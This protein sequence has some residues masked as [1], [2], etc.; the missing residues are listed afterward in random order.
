MSDLWNVN[1]IRYCPFSWRSAKNQ[2]KNTVD[3]GP[4]QFGRG[5]HKV[6]LRGIKVK[7]VSRN[8]KCEEEEEIELKNDL[9]SLTVLYRAWWEHVLCLQ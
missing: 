9:D 2:G 3:Q 5:L 8:I 6:S 4:R 7:C 1:K